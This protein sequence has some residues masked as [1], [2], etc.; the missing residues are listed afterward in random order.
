MTTRDWPSV[1]L[2]RSSSIPATVLTAA[3]MRS[4]ISVST[5][6]GAAPLLVVL[7]DTVGSSIRG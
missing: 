6:S 2:E 7:T 3:S 4:E 1:E 5:F